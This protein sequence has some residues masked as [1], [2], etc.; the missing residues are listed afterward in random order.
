[1]RIPGPR[2]RQIQPTD[3][4][5]WAHFRQMSAEALC[6]V[7]I[8]TGI[9]AGKDMQALQSSPPLHTR[10]HTHTA[11]LQHTRTGAPY[12]WLS[13]A[14]RVRVAR[15][16]C[17]EPADGKTAHESLTASNRLASLDSMAGVA[18]A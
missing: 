17:Q 11:T 1:M 2:W 10:T 12:I 16:P 15:L 5:L 9:H 7:Y 14:A 13:F 8:Q 6:R 4:S 18:Q 3:D